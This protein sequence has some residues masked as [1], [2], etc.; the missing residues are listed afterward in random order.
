MPFYYDREFAVPL[1][2][3]EAAMLNRA[4]AT[5]P[6]TANPA[7]TGPARLWYS[8]FF[9]VAKGLQG[10][11]PS[12]NTYALE[13]R[14][15]QVFAIQGLERIDAGFITAS[16]RLAGSG[17]LGSVRIR[18]EALEQAVCAQTD[19][20]ELHRLPAPFLLRRGDVRDDYLPE[21]LPSAGLTP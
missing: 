4:W 12:F 16:V 21:R 9:A 6:R 13:S 5:S 7:L 11:P 1:S 8:R 3:P 10:L 14:R 20:Y 17:T 19:A 2:D 15:D 18:I